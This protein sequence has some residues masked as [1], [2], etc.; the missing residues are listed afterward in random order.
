MFALQHTHPVD[1]DFAFC[2]LCD[3]GD[4]LD[5][6]NNG[7]HAAPGANDPLNNDGHCAVVERETSLCSVG[8]ASTHE[9][10]AFLEKVT[11]PI[12]LLSFVE[13]QTVDG[14]YQYDW[15]G[16]GSSLGLEDKLLMQQAMHSYHSVYRRDQKSHYIFQQLYHQPFCR[17]EDMQHG[18][19]R[20]SHQYHGCFRVCLHLIKRLP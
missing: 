19:L 3:L 1:F 17:L 18:I 14:L 5:A 6:C 8:H 9:N 11:C 15:I 20:A 4:S 7:D 2:H 13:N 10:T 16:A 12:A